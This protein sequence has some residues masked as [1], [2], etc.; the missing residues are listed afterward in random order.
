MPFPRFLLTFTGILYAKSRIQLSSGFWWT[1]FILFPHFVLDF[2]GELFSC[3]FLNSLWISYV[4]Y[5]TMPARPSPKF[6]C[7]CIICTTSCG[8]GPDGTPLGN[9]IPESQCISHLARAKAETEAQRR[10]QD[11]DIQNASSSLFASTLVDEGPNTHAQPSR[12]W[13]S[14]QEYQSLLKSIR[15]VMR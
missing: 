11:S 15:H 13:I 12:F 1:R 4:H 5:K 3:L 10:S 6:H 14:R 8:T 9:F 2:V 7:L